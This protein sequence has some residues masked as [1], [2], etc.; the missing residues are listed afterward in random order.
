MTIDDWT[1]DDGCRGMTPAVV[2]GGAAGRRGRAY[3]REWR[4]LVCGWGLLDVGRLT[5][6]DW[7]DGRWVPGN[8]AG[9]KTQHPSPPWTGRG[10]RGG[11]MT[12][13][14]T[15]DDGRL[16]MGGGEWRRR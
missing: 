13:A 2:S 15:M 6:D 10:S 3:A 4:W 5:I 11:V 1:T 9:N 14:L 8:G 16:T 7:D 12:P